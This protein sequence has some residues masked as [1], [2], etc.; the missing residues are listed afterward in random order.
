LEFRPPKFLLR[1][2]LFCMLIGTLPT[3]ILGVF[4]YQKS[5][6]IIEDKVAKGNMLNLEQTQLSVE[7]LLKT[8]EFSAIQFTNSSLVI[9]SMDKELSPNQFQT[10]NSLI[11]GLHNLQS[12]E[13]RINDILLV[14]LN[15]GWVIDNS[16]EV[17]RLEQYTQTNLIDEYVNVEKTSFWATTNDGAQVHLVK[18]LPLNSL[19]PSG[20]IVI[21]FNNKEINKFLINNNDLGEVMI[22]DHNGIVIAHSNSVNVGK[23]WRGVKELQSL[24]NT[25]DAVGD[26]RSRSNGD[27]GVTYRKSSY[28]GWIYVSISPVKLIT[29][30]SEVIKWYT[31]TACILI[32]LVTILLSWLV[33]RKM[34]SPISRLYS[35]LTEKQEVSTGE[36]RYDELQY[37]GSQVHEMFDAKHRLTGIIEGQQRHVDEL[38]IIKLYQGE[39]RAREIHDHMNEIAG[40]RIWHHICVIAVQID[41]L[42]G[43]RY[44]EKDEDLLL[45]VINNMV[46]EIVQASER[47]NPVVMHQTQ[48]TLIGNL[49]LS[50]ELFKQ[51]INEIA[52]EIRSKVDEYLQLN[53]S[54]GIS[55]FYSTVESAQGA[56]RD[57]TE[58]LKYT[59]RLG[60]GSIIHIV[61]AEPEGTILSHIPDEVRQDLLDAIKLADFARADLLLDTYLHD[62]FNEK[63]GHREYFIPLTSLL[64]DLMRM[65]QS[66]GGTIVSQQNGEKS[67]IDQLYTLKSIKEIELWFREYLIYPLIELFEKKRK[68]QYAKI[69]DQMLAMIHEEAETDL[70]LDL[71]AS[72][73]GYHPDYIRGVFR[74]EVGENFS[75]YLSNYRLQLAKDMLV[76]TEMKIWEIAER[77]CYNN[78]QNFIRY[79]RKQV[80]ITPGQY[81][82]NK[83]SKE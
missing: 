55:R 32:V 80:G 43:T 6:E 65:A 19:S 18:N 10:V 13:F 46:G 2:F 57:A 16:T 74:K 69:S 78:S 25:T 61:D 79:F 15:R 58:A 62:I 54:V 12:F 8:V 22:L 75:D 20:L 64:L 56:Y 3:L 63:V 17:F 30:D 11:E 33:S 42:E 40:A 9:S 66:I 27:I 37:I 48:V 44:G 31:Y 24:F 14:S 39:I 28:N 59:I 82:E 4:S 81:R 77:L 5:S 23:D 83:L 38:F 60:P 35:F 73:L 67:L 49:G 29:K 7:Q 47:L 51:H 71:C 72:R 21:K 36:R 50:E 70:T 45:Y 68:Y 76:H 53:V 26:Y 52:A 34:Y 1:L 41:T